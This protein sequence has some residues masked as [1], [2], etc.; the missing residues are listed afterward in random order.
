MRAKISVFIAM[1]LSFTMCGCSV[2]EGD[3]DVDNM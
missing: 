1:V 2:R 3:N